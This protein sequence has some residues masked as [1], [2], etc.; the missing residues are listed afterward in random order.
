[1]IA[2]TR[3]LMVTEI[4]FGDGLTS[5]HAILARYVPAGRGC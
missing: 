1:M 2:E 5:G 3:F 4:V